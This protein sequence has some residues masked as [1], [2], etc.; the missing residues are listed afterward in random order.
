MTVTVAPVVPEDG[1][2]PQLGPLIVQVKGGAP[3]SATLTVIGTVTEA[4]V[5]GLGGSI[6]GMA[7][8]PTSTMSS[9]PAALGTLGKVIILSPSNQ[10][11]R[12]ILMRGRSLS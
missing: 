4:A 2:A 3:A 6:R 12:E 7:M 1:A 5:T 10:A 11:R 8:A 9:T